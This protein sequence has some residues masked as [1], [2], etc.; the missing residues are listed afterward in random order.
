MPADFQVEPFLRQAKMA[1]I[2]LQAANDAKDLDD[3][4]DYTTPEMYAEIAM[5]IEERVDASQ[6]T[7]AIN[8]H[9]TLLE[10]VSEGGYE[11]ASVRFAGLMRESDQGNPEP[12]D[13]VWHV[14]KKLNDRRAAWLISGIQQRQAA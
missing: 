6:K 11:I 12:F 5:Q 1:F 9:P 2:R 4:R 10:V 7:E 14:Q 3:I 8:V 13:E